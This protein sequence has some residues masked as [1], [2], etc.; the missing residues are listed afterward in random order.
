MKGYT[1]Y[2]IEFLHDKNNN[3]VPKIST[4]YGDILN[5]NAR[6]SQ[7]SENKSSFFGFLKRNT[8][9]DVEESFLE[10]LDPILMQEHSKNDPIFMRIDINYENHE[11]M[12]V[13]HKDIETID[14]NTLEEYKIPYY[15]GYNTD[16]LEKMQSQIYKIAEVKDVLP[17][18]F[19]L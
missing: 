1:E 8:G 19:T 9:N 11:V 5:T 14:I 12:N 16:T 15:E 18:I 4:N 2:S 17:S 6:N 3:I 10:Q 7:P 13:V